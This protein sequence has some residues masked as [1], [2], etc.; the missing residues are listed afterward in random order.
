MNIPISFILTIIWTILAGAALTILELNRSR[1]G[2]RFAWAKNRIL[3]ISATAFLIISLIIGII[4][5][6]T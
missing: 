3:Q 1:Y 5:K 2:S 6:N 4:I